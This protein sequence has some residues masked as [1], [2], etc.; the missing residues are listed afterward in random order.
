MRHGCLSSCQS[1]ADWRGGDR[2]CVMATGRNAKTLF[3]SSNEKKNPQAEVHFSDQL[4]RF[5][6]APQIRDVFSIGRPG[7]VATG[8]RFR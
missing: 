2:E 7:R 8:G 5:A 3:S 6:L 4:S 1:V